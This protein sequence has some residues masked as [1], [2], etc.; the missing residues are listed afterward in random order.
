MKR[1]DLLEKPGSTLLLKS[2]A[3]SD[4]TNLPAIVSAWF[5]LFPADVLRQHRKGSVSVAAVVFIDAPFRRATAGA[6]DS[7]GL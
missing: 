6:G 4:P 2:A 5:P 3:A 1:W 7:N